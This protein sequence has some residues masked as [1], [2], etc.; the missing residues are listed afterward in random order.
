MLLD[1]IVS[2]SRLKKCNIYYIRIILRLEFIFIS[3][4]TEKIILRQN[5]YR[6]HFL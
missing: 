1:R 6:P 3:S 5:Q 4:I 2:H